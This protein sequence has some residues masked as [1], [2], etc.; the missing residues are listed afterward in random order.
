MKRKMA[1]IRVE[2]VDECEEE[3]NEKIA[4]ELLNWFREEVVF[5][6]WVKNVK[7]ITVENG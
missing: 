6:P 1:I 2:L 4:Q 5:V 7:N 3:R